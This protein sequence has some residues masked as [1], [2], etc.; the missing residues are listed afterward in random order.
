MASF[1]ILILLTCFITLSGC[2]VSSLD[3]FSN[4][5]VEQVETVA[6]SP[7]ILAIIFWG[8]GSVLHRW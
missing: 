2:A 5:G 7:S 6:I 8:R 1:R 3:E 4:S